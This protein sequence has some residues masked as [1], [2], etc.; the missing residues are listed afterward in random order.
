MREQVKDIRYYLEIFQKRK[1]LL[2]IPALVI[3]LTVTVVA[4]LLP[5][6]YESSCTILIEEQQIPADFVRSTVTGFAEQR[7]QSLTQQ[8]LSRSRL[9]EIIEKFDL[10]PEMKE[11]YTKE[12]ITKKMRKDIKI[13]MISAEFGDRPRPRKAASGQTGIMIAF[14]ISYRGQD[15]GKLQKAAGTLS[16][17]Y[18]EQNIKLRESQAQSTTQFLE[19]ELKNLEKRIQFLGEQISKFK[20]KHEG[21][22]PELQQFNLSQAEH[23]ENDIKQLDVNIRGA[24]ERKIYLEGQLATVRKDSMATGGERGDPVSR[25]RALEV[26]LADMRSK[27]SADHPDIRKLLR[28]KGELEKIVGK[29]GGSGSQGR[30]KLAELKME[31][32][33][34]QG[35]YSE[36][37]PDILKLKK[38]IEQLEGE[39]RAK[40]PSLPDMEADNP[41]Y[42]SLLTQIKAAGIETDS[43]KKQR[44][45]LVEKLQTYR[46]RLEGTPKVEQEYLAFQRDYANAHQKHQEVM[47]K[48]L[49][50]RIAEGMEEHQKGEKFSIIDAANFPEEPIQPKRPLIIMAGLFFGL[51]TGCGVVLMADSLDHSVK[52]PDE[53][54]WLTGMPVLGSIKQI[55][56]PEDVQRERS[57]RRVIWATIG[58]SLV[59]ALVLFHLF[60]MDFHI[61]MAKILRFVHKHS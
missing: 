49:E 34:K 57:K 54:A 58:V 32:A 2:I 36:Q 5:P 7:I 56:I 24:E 39:Q 33:Q 15:P 42:V 14:T 48:I 30:Q 51:I 35:K 13:D 40:K 12:E 26:A 44:A 23:L 16:S 21:M 55:T 6:V 60:Y 27:F 37:H 22:L 43:L 52:T 11:K 9:L 4:L 50:A 10:Y 41:S 53:L 18:L 31:L 28:E 29:E 19:A 59:L 17:L 45:N 3:L 8:L 25:L 61:L 47:N 20:E 38:E 46:K 1:K